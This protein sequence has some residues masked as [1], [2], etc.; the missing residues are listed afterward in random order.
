MNNGVAQTW[1]G[2][3][4]NAVNRPAS[5]LQVI[6]EACAGFILHCQ[7]IG[8][9]V[10][11]RSTEK[12]DQFVMSYTTVGLTQICV[13]SFKDKRKKKQTVKISSRVTK[14]FE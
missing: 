9:V 11:W 7:C 4:N 12:L 8:A 1:H 3:R 2:V 13:C 10:I 6:P 5:F 14:E